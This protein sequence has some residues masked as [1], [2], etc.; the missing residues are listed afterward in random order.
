MN[1]L[2][3]KEDY[4]K[5]TSKELHD[6]II[7]NQILFETTLF[8]KHDTHFNISIPRYQDKLKNQ[9][10]RYYLEELI[11]GYEA[12]TQNNYNHFLEELADAY[13]F[14]Y[15][16]YLFYYNFDESKLSWLHT[17]P[18]LSQGTIGEVSIDNFK[19]YLT[20]I[21]IQVHLLCN[22]LKNRYWSQ[23]Q[24]IIYDMNFIEDFKQVLELF[25]TL[26]K[27][28]GITTEILYDTTYKKLLVNQFRIGSQ[29]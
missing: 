10:Q 26:C 25:Y 11:E 22:R 17:R 28:C 12:I 24:K 14:L 5:I 4:T 6:K 16:S 9:L 1:I 29:Y 15:S 18:T 13:I 23:A 7:T 21:T 3:I 27:V 20:D 19:K 8:G 2:D